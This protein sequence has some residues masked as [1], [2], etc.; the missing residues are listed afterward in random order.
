MAQQLL[1]VRQNLRWDLNHWRQKIIASKVRTLVGFELIQISKVLALVIGVTFSAYCLVTKNSS[2][3]KSFPFF[4]RC[5]RFSI[6][7]TV[8][9][10]HKSLPPT[11]THQKISHKSRIK[12]F[13]VH[14]Q[15]VVWWLMR[16]RRKVLN[17][18]W[19]NRRSATAVSLLVMFPSL[20]VQ[21]QQ[22]KCF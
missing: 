9:N 12:P 13:P 3:N 18:V 6:N 17:A 19:S 22:Q 8:Q 16:R 10:H 7:K 14:N 4:F 2:L 15:R 1:T 21:L 11:A 20:L 5:R